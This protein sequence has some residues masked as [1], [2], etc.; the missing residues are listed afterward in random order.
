M[1]DLPTSELIISFEVKMNAEILDARKSFANFFE[2]F[3][4]CSFDLLNSGK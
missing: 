3:I 1:I 2:Y 4:T